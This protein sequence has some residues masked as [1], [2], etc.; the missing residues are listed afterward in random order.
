MTSIRP[1]Q[2]SAIMSIN[3][4][5]HDMPSDDMT[6]IRPW[7]TSAIMSINKR[8]HDMPSDDM[9]SIRPW[10]TNATERWQPQEHQTRTR[11]FLLSTAIDL[12]NDRGQMTPWVVTSGTWVV[13][14]WTLDCRD[15]WQHAGLHT[16]VVVN[17]ALLA[18][19]VHAGVLLDTPL[20][21]SDAGPNAGWSL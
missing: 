1:W 11:T 3:K 20:K 16:W 15:E 2:T 13:A 4:R 12:S 21:V 9:T 5:C 14:T 6:S 18:W 17:D 10:Q 7:Q 8:C 19:V